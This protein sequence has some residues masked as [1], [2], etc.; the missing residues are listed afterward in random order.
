MSVLD[1]C[2]YTT[3]NYVCRVDLL[4]IFCYI[5]ASKKLHNFSLSLSEIFL[6]IGHIEC[7]KY[8]SHILL[9]QNYL[10]TLQVYK[11]APLNPSQP[12]S[13]PNLTPPFNKCM[14]PM[15]LAK[16]LNSARSRGGAAFSFMKMKL[17]QA[18][19]QEKSFI[20]NTGPKTSNMSEENSPKKRLA[21]KLAK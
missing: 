16:R 19:L 5:S 8:C 6:A 11:S 13:Y 10:T 18:N 2:W 1:F 17:E 4:C 12:M 9:R 15:R 14:R 20:G 3:K 7:L 21:G